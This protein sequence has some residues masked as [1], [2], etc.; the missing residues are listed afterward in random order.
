MNLLKELGDIR[1][2]IKTVLFNKID[3]RADWPKDFLDVTIF[4]LPKK[5]QE[6][7]CS[8]HRPI[9]LIS[10]TGK[11]VARILSKRLG[12]KIEEFIEEDPG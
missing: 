2:K 10:H 5:N 9:S 12:S 11:I 8:D 7:K 1:F 6:K 3:I 4:A